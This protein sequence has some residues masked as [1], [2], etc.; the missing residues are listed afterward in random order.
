MTDRKGRCAAGAH[1][2]AP[3][4]W[5]CRPPHPS[6]LQALAVPMLLVAAA[7]RL[8]AS[9]VRPRGLAPISFIKERAGGSGTAVLC[10]APRPALLPSDLRP[11]PDGAA[12]GS[13]IQAS[14]ESPGPCTACHKRGVPASAAVGLYGEGPGGR[15]A[16]HSAQVERSALIQQPT[17]GQPGT[18]PLAGHAPHS[19]SGKQL[20]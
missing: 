10:G 11:L 4:G 6:F 19:P 12:R 14:G 2:Q 5:L 7:T 18:G 17:R 1:G 13:L 9:W 8:H 20:R 15:P 16:V 3:P